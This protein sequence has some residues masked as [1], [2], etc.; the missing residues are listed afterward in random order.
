MKTSSISNVLGSGAAL[1][2]FLGLASPRALAGPGPQYWQSLG[3]AKAETVAPAAQA[4]GPVCTDA[5]VV[6]DTVTKNAWGN[7]RGP[8]VT[9]ASSKKTECTVCG[10]FTVMKPSWHNGRG[11]LQ[12]VQVSGRHDCTV[13]C[14]KPAHAP[15]TT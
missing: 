3:K 10:T 6:A 15:M 4:P 14:E 7:G 1:T 13:A 9:T 8:L 5:K 11:P 2:L 12:P